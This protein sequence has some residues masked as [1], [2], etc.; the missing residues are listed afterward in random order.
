MKL[1]FAQMVKKSLKNGINKNVCKASFHSLRLLEHVLQ[2]LVRITGFKHNLEATNVLFGERMNEWMNERMNEWMNEWMNEVWW[3]NECS[4]CNNSNYES[5]H[6]LRFKSVF[7]LLTEDQ[8][9]ACILKPFAI[10]GENVLRD[11]CAA[12]PLFICSDEREDVEN[13]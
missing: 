8:S 4:S 2:V 5:W 6:L 11:V 13:L 9:S 12:F 1:L 7:H 10:S 3:I